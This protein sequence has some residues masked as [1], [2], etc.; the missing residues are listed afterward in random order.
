MAQRISKRLLEDV[1]KPLV[2]RGLTSDIATVSRT[3]DG[4]QIAVVPLAGKEVD[5]ARCWPD[6]QTLR[7]HIGVPIVYKSAGP[8]RN[9][10]TLE[11]LQV[12]YE[13]ATETSRESLEAMCAELAGKAEWWDTI[14]ALEGL[15]EEMRT[16]G[17]EYGEKQARRQASNTGQ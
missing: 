5:T 13:Y 16:I 15:A 10:S 8:M 17:N 11:Q 7:Q 9:W 1:R 3:V 2:V 4:T 14:D 12:I 6:V